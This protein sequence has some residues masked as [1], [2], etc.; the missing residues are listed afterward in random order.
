MLTLGRLSVGSK[1]RKRREERIEG[2]LR[3][4][5]FKR[6]CEEGRLCT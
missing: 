2:L 4:K 6:V 3:V 1:A 5:G